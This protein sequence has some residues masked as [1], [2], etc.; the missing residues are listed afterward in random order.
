MNLVST[1][2]RRT[3]DIPRRRT[4]RIK[5]NE[6]GSR[7]RFTNRR[8]GRRGLTL[9]ECAVTLVV[10]SISV[11]FLLQIDINVAGDVRHA[12][13]AQMASRLA[14]LILGRSILGSLPEEIGI[15]ET[16]GRTAVD[17]DDPWLQD[18]DTQFFPYASFEYEVIK[19]IEEVDAETDLSVSGTE[20]DEQELQGALPP[21]GQPAAQ[22]ATGESSVRLLYV[23]VTV[24]FPDSR[25]QEGGFDEVTVA[26]YRLLDD[27][28]QA[29]GAFGPAGGPGAG[30][31]AQ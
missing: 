19:R 13:N 6:Q 7:L 30:G 3:L 20:R 4:P 23:E 10:V 27:E 2:S 12:S 18:A 17:P 28:D 21:A 5:Q 11:A 16:S 24:W 22:S 26:T 31:S 9:I 14:G 8:Q 15:D 29:Q 25:G 1:S